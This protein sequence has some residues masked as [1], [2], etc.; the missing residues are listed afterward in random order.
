MYRNEERKYMTLLLEFAAD[1][2]D[3]RQRALSQIH[4]RLSYQSSLAKTTQHSLH[5]EDC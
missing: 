2:N 5:I 3:K 4:K 1:E